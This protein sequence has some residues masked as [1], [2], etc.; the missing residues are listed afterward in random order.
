MLWVNLRR[1][2]RGQSFTLFLAHTYKSN[3]NYKKNVVEHTS[4]PSR[5][6]SFLNYIDIFLVATPLPK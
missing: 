3:S 1:T 5:K 4:D 6:F 2:K